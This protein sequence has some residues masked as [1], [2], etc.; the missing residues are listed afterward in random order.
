MGFEDILGDES[1]LGGRK[2]VFDRLSS[3][4]ED[5]NGTKSGGDVKQSFAAA[6]G[7][8]NSEELS[9]FPLENKSQSKVVLPVEL[10]RE[11]LKT[12]HTTLYG[13][14]LGPRVPFPVVEGYVKNL[15]RKFGFVKAM[16]NNNGVMF[17]KFNDLGGC[18][19]VIAN[20][21][22]MVRGAPMFVAQWDPLKA[23]SKPM[24]KSCPL[25]VKLHN[26]PLVAFNK[27]GISRIAS[28]L[29]VPKQMDSC[30]AAMC[31]KAWGRPGFAKVLVEVWALG[32]LKRELE[33]VIP[34][35]DG[36]ED[37]S[38]TI[39]VEYIWEPSQC[40]HCLVFGH[41]VTSCAKAVLVQQRVK[42]VGKV[43]DEGFVTV[44]RK[45]WKPKVNDL[46]S[47]SGV[48]KDVNVT[49]PVGSSK[50]T[51]IPTKESLEEKEVQSAPVVESAPVVDL[52]GVEGRVT[53]EDV[54]IPDLSVPD[55]RGKVE[56]GEKE[57]HDLNSPEFNP[58]Y[59]RTSRGSFTARRGV[60]V[61]T[62]IPKAVGD[63]TRGNV[64][65]PLANLDDVEASTIEKGKKDSGKKD[66]GSA[67]R[68]S[69][70]S[71]LNRGMSKDGKGACWNIRGLNASEKQRELKSFLRVNDINLCAVLES[72]LKQDMLG[73]VVNNVFGRWSWIS[74]QNVSLHG[75]RIIVAWNSS[76]MD[77]MVLENHPQFIHCEIKVR[78]A[79]DPWM[80]TF[81]YG[82]NNTSLRKQLWSGLR[83]FRAIIGNQPWVV[84]G[85]FNAML[86]PHDALG[87]MSKR[88]VDMVDFFEC[89]EDVEV[90]DVR[91]SG[92]QHT[93]CQK[94][95]E[96]LGLRRKLDRILANVEFISR[97]EDANA[98][99]LPRGIS[100]HSPG[101]LA[102]KGGTRR[103][104]IGF[105]FDNFLVEHPTFMSIV[106]S[107]WDTQINGTFMY[108][109]TSR[110]KL[111]KQPLRKLRLSYGNLTSKVNALKDELD[112]V[113]LACDMDPFNT[114]LKEDLFAIRIAYQQ[115]C[116]DEAVAARQRAKVHWLKDGDANTKFFHNVVRERRHLNQVRS[117][118]KVDGVFV[119]DD[120]VPMAFVEHL[121]SY[122]GTCDNSLDPVI[123][124]AWF[125]NSL[126]LG[127]ALYMI[128]P[129]LDSEIRDA[130]FQIGKDKAPGSDGFT[131]QFFKA[132]W[133]LVGV[134]VSVAIHNFFYRG[135]IAKEIN[136][137]L[138]C[139]LP[140]SPNASSVS[141]FRPI[142]CCS[143][144][145]KCISKVVVNRMK[146]FLDRLV[147][148]SQ[149]AF[150]PGRRIV[151]NILMA[152]ELVIGYHLNSGKPRCAFKIDLRKAYDMVDW[153][154]L[155]NM[156]TGFG[157]HPVM[158]A[159]I[160]EMVTTTT[161]SV[162]VNGESSGFFHGKRGIRQGD[163]LS[164]YLFTLVMEGFS[165][166][167]KQCIEETNQFQHHPGCFD[168]DLTHLCFA[169]D[170][171]V[172]TGGD[173]A[174]VEILKKALFLFEK[175]AGLAPNLSKSDVFFG[176]VPDATKD[177]I[178][179][180]LPFRMGSFPI[181]YLGVPLSPVF[182][183]VSEYGGLIDRV[184]QRIQNWK[185]KSLSFGGRRQLVISVLQSL[186]LYWMAIF[187]FPSSV[188]H[189][190][191][192]LFRAFLWSQG[193]SIQGKCRVAWDIVC[194]SR[195]CG[196]LGIKNLTLWNRAL[197][198][199]NLWDIISDR[200]TL[201]VAWVRR[202][203]GH[204]T[205]FWIIRTNNSWSWVLRKMM[206][207]KDLIRP[208]VRMVI[209]DG[210]NAHAWEDTW[211]DIGPLA[212]L[213]SYRRIHAQG[214]T[215]HTTVNEF[216]DVTGGV[217]PNEWVVRYP[218]LD[219]IQLP[220]LVDGRD[221]IRWQKAQHELV[222]FS[223]KIAYSSLDIA[224]NRIEWT[225]SV[226]FKGH[227]PKHAFCLWVACH[228]RLPTQDRL[229]NWKHVPPDW[230]CSLCGVC[231]DS[232]RHL[233]FACSF[234]STVWKEVT[235]A[236]DW[237]NAPNDWDILLEM[238]SGPNPPRKFAHRLGLAATVYGVWNERNRRLFTLDRKPEVLCAKE[239]IEVIM[240][241]LA[242]KK[243]MKTKSIDDTDDL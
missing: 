225:S 133:E 160:K 168:I 42:K 188:L 153:R 196:G 5:T 92:I 238:L 205:N 72:H 112:V 129:I 87:G 84:L 171:F 229:L 194:R 180:C 189:E 22:L 104:H 169:D 96:D 47:S 148:K 17:F 39:K 201:W 50:V 219:T 80:C 242:W 163:P 29:G 79:V 62:A 243:M 164:P 135:H 240:M 165:M 186:Q 123:P 63:D 121:K 237:P 156:L 78:G 67:E 106:K 174:S 232:H 24:H 187:V 100:D 107:V 16:M 40:S 214:F 11:A 125:R 12:H 197:I 44:E 179:E 212:S 226:W 119:Y 234:T 59:V 166:I 116:R 206:A 215:V 233:F 99:F 208:Y 66:K 204:A 218:N 143:T 149:S 126:S 115:V 146:P 211:L 103:K 31:E 13:Y 114:E 76:F 184:K 9:F 75:T 235:L 140:K 158:V 124:S 26:V 55:D 105:K 223:V 25:W 138:I 19:Q 85:D 141:D 73:S 97:F 36:G 192:V 198:A 122:L 220:M 27:E 202:L 54:S 132:A 195:D 14:F 113:Q 230:K 241:R 94:P 127:D 118:C 60:F 38:V 117:V 183:K 33:L 162:V 56:T 98:R 101:L 175:K 154:F 109:V 43:D 88:N 130:M 28:A 2:S 89:I 30:T 64:F 200:P 6:V 32:E 52:D 199:K 46:P 69:S 34:N 1:N 8:A 61:P 182:L 102:F 53:T 228:H 48:V 65:S 71:K 216:L 21:P 178:L 236:I 49:K 210:R 108:R 155:C 45:Q 177:A 15:W 231:M 167:L 137:T 128:R 18:N 51:K 58:E 209:G 185:V 150:I 221:A 217:W 151:D 37:S 213:I 222:D 227:I 90:F 224:H 77:V 120:D 172:F 93:W 95:K 23:L 170:L 111:L 4:V 91:Y 193:E 131:S 207:L 110:L 203:I 142:S 57:L 144:L 181:R 191:E 20:G 7:N 3:N 239:I 190:L 161:Y 86:F 136:H 10:T 35:L 159:W 68:S 157:F 82:A 139:L 70:G 173:V 81:V 145:Y 74:N 41:K 147:G 134:D 176:N 83:K 152:H